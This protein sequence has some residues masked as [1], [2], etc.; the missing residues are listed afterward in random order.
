MAIGITP[1][2]PTKHSEH[3]QRYSCAYPKLTEEWRAKHPETEPA[4]KLLERILAERRQ[5]WEEGQLAR[6]AAAD[7]T[8][9]KGWREKYVEPA[10]PDASGLPDLPQGWCWASPEQLASADDYALAIGPFGSNLKVSDY[11]DDGVPLVFVRNIRSAN[12]GGVSTKYISEEKARE[13]KAHQIESG[14]V[15]ITKMGDPP[16]DS[17]L[18]PEGSPTAVITADCIKFRLA[19]LIRVP[20]FFALAINS[21]VVHRQIMRI[22]KGVAQQKVSL[23][24]FSTIALPLPSL[25]EQE[26]IVSEVER[27]FSIIAAADCETHANLVRAARLRQSILKRAFEGR[28]VPQDPTDEPAD[29]LLERTRQKRATANASVAPRNRRGR[30]ARQQAEGG[31]QEAES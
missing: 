13:L 20:Q 21:D 28:F 22:T 27:Q 15:L 2:H 24:R 10:A 17:C 19:K 14:D 30:A 4:S 29:K 5:K 31:T 18:Y 16:G 1:L 7:K 3:W 11:A 25:A 8:P 9:P 6:F 26:Q 12:F 23:A